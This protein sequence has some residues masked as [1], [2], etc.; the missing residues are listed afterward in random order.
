MPPLLWCF[1]VI[2]VLII[3]QLTMIAK[4]AP[5]FPQ[6]LFC[7]PFKIVIFLILMWSYKDRSFTELL[8]VTWPLLSFIGPYFA[9][10]LCL[11]SYRDTDGRPDAPKCLK[12]KPKSLV[13]TSAQSSSTGDVGSSETSGNAATSVQKTSMCFLCKYSSLN[14]V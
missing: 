11:R 7:S 3:Y 1:C 14:D 8:K 4:F 2:E 10:Q 13:R 12:S 5:Y 9:P 6:Y